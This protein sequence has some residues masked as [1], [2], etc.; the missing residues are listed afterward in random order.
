LNNKIIRLYNFKNIGNNISRNNISRNNISRNNI[1]RNNISQNNIYIKDNL[2][3]EISKK[4]IKC[5]FDIDC[6]GKILM[7]GFFDIQINGANNIL[8]NNL[9][10]SDELD[11]ICLQLLKEGITSFFAT[12]I[13]PSLNEMKNFFEIY[14]KS[15]KIKNL[16]GIHIEGP[17]IEKSKKGIHPENKIRIPDNEDINLIQKNSDIIKLITLSSEIVDSKTINFLNKS[18]I[19]VFAGHSDISYEN[20]IKSFKNNIKGI[21]HIFNS[22]SGITA[23]NPGLALAAIDYNVYTSIIADFNHVHESLLIRL[24]K[25]NIDKRILISDNI[26]INKNNYEMNI[27]DQKIFK[28]NNIMKNSNDI[29]AG[30]CLSIKDIFLN[31]YTKKILTLYELEKVTSKNAA[32]LFKVNTAEI[33][34]GKLA[35]LILFDYQN[36]KNQQIETI[37]I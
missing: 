3:C 26:G 16:K 28:K 13:S 23:R 8:F 10:K 9:K 15:K 31:L 19:T 12:L 27:F 30:S 14:R 6:K 20:A 24:F 22:M 33:A 25:E 5:S 7:P 35:E 32:K 4:I 37:L 29:I 17:F 34:E 2:I 18:N 21:T 11:F 1:S 36:K